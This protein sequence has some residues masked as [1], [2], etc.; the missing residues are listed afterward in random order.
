MSQRTIRRPPQPNA[1]RTARFPPAVLQVLRTLDAAGH[2]SWLVGGAVRD[3]LLRRVRGTADHDIATPARPA[4]VIALFPRTIP[5]G[6]EHGTVTVLVRGEKIEVTTFR[7]EGPYVDG[8]RPSQVT[9]LDDVD[10]DLARRDFTVNAMAWDPIGAVFRDP[11]GGRTDLRRRLLRAVGDAAARF[12][13]DGLRPL[14]AA[15]F[16]AQLGF[17]VE[18]RTA[19]A[20]PGALD[21]VRRVALERITDE[22]SR[23]LIAQDV[24]LGLELLRRTRLLGVVLPQ[25]AA[26]PSRGL[27]H[28]VAVTEAAPPQLSVRLA[29]LVHVVPG[30]LGAE[31]ERTV[32]S[33][34]GGLRFSGAVRDAAVALLV[35][36]AVSLRVASFRCRRTT[37]RRG[38]GSRASGRR[39][40]VCWRWVRRRSGLWARVPAR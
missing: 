17:V 20:I 32:A 7:G 25:L 18:P 28:A 37:P 34:L 19:A 5:T 35:T 36:A 21:T 27:T 16:A 3:V 22:L 33:L 10:G 40:T 38:A 11:F 26:V 30:A 9:F 24:R 39:G 14:R 31:A 2:R 23:L 15:R 6:I 1:L 8:R 13:E 29:A 12:G 4:Q